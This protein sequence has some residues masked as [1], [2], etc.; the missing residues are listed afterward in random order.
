MSGS[1]KSDDDMKEQWLR[2]QQMQADILLKKQAY[3]YFPAQLFLNI[4]VAAA[5]LVTAVF[6]G[7]KLV[8]DH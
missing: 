5:A 8:F 6:A 2:M 3:R 4:T 7:L 1:D